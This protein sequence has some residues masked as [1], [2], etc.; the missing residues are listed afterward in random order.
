MAK[1]V[2]EESWAEDMESLEQEKQ[3]LEQERKECEQNLRSLRGQEDPA[4]GRVYAQEIHALLVKKL[5]LETELEFCRRKR[6]RI[7][8]EKGLQ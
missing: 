2:A 4:S 8:L 5:Q 7:M 3:R 1:K 6:N